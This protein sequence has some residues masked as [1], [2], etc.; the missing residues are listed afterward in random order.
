M[1]YRGLLLLACFFA[2]S[3]SAVTPGPTPVASAEQLT[4]T[5][6]ASLAIPFLPN[7]GQMDAR[8]AYYA[9]LFTGTVFVTRDGEI[10]Y[11]L[12]TKSYR[13]SEK[14]WV[15]TERLATSSLLKPKAGD[16]T[17]TRANYFIGRDPSLWQHDVPTYG[18]VSLGRPWPGIEV[19]LTA[20]ADH[21]ETFYNVAAG[22]DVKH[23]RLKLSGAKKLKIKG[24]R[25]L[26]ETGLGQVA[27]ETPRAWQTIGG[28]RRYVPVRY[29]LHHGSYGFEIGDHDSG[30]PVVIDPDFQATYLG[31]PGD[32][33]GIVAG[34]AVGPAGDVYVLGNTW[35]LEQFP[36]TTGGAQP[37]D[38][39][40]GSCCEEMFVA[41][42]NAALTSLEQATYLGAPDGGEDPA[43]L[44]LDSAGDVYVAGT[45][46]NAVFPGVTGGALSTHSGQQAGFI[47]KLNPDLTALDQST[48]LGSTDGSF[49][50]ALAVGAD[51]DVYAA[52]YTTSTT[53]SGTSAGAQPTIGGGFDAFVVGLN[54]N[55]TAFLGATYLGGSNSDYAS[56][57]T[58][59]AAGDV[60][61][62]GDTDS[63]DFPGTTGGAQATLNLN[64]DAFIAKLNSTLTTLEQATYLGGSGS[65]GW[66]N[67]ALDADGDVYVAGTT[68]SSDF[69]HTSGG[70][71]ASFNGGNEAF[72]AKLKPGLTS[73][74]QATYLG[75]SGVV[76]TDVSI[77]PDGDVYV[78][79]VTSSGDFPGTSGGVQPAFAGGGQDWYVARLNPKLTMPY[80]ATYLG[81]TGSEN[82]GNVVLVP[83]FDAAGDVYVAG[84]TLSDD[85]PGTAGGAE[86]TPTPTV[87]AK[88]PADLK[89]NASLKLY[90]DTEPL[91]HDNLLSLL[92]GDFDDIS[93]FVLDQSTGADATGIVF[94]V[95]LPPNL[96]LQFTEPE[97]GTCDAAGQVITC[98]ATNLDLTPGFG[99]NTQIGVIAVNS[100]PAT[101][102]AEITHVDQDIATN[103]I[104]SAQLAVVVVDTSTTADAGSVNTQ[105]G[106]AVNA[107]LSASNPC[108]CGTPVYKIVTAPGHG[109][110]AIT[111]NT[112]GA[113]TYTPA[114]GYV[115]NDSFVFELDNGVG[116]ST[117][118]TEQ[119][120]VGDIAPSVNDGSVSTKAGTAVSG[121]LSGTRAYAGQT[122]IFGIASQP[123]HGSVSLAA[124]TG[125]FTYKPAAGFVGTDSFTFQA[126]DAYGTPSNIATVNVTVGDIAP[127]ANGGMLKLKTRMSSYSGVLKAT[128]AY[129][130][131]T[132]TFRIVGTPSQGSITITNPS[133]GAYTLTGAPSLN[134]RSSFTFQVVDQWG[135]VSNTAKVT[136]VVL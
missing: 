80:N 60:Y 23:I 67:V 49:V 51:G 109:N 34:Y 88:L 79:G 48:Y 82:L 116:S 123:A 111:N 87:V 39:R 44:A 72:V 106:Q 65:E 26:A 78:G 31:I 124:R 75:G 105:F 52:G 103:S 81:G 6:L 110:A 17:S 101:I 131:Q 25:L 97:Y 2:V 61:V 7:Q 22:T 100:G 1:R 113:F 115:G 127:K 29:V 30:L 12:P 70:A 33:S 4:S 104:T 54:S 135:T 59:D 35:S 74:E 47:A 27:F 32:G 46:Y 99:F 55:L 18:S 85:I 40:T 14:G 114:G 73:L 126:T 76:T 90:F 21:V 45:T 37:T 130:G 5:D 41:K 24:G 3:A 121:T 53:I 20:H 134:V 66:P 11:S 56:G 36:G 13:H 102:A 64:G 107:S 63:S 120:T 43:G 136:V 91:A 84:A 8:V 98:R 69:P 83:V 117:P 129:W 96:S 62:T 128:A 9:P 15:L 119:V 122:M 42:L 68:T 112:T 86:S 57:V 94:T 108:D 77:A 89:A 16:A 71:Q 95:T 38:M 92:P 93:I 58:V 28:T 118:A 132:L 19:S 133:T 125:K 10:V 50:T